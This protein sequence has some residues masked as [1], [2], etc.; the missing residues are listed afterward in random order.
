MSR[1]F[2][3]GLTFCENCLKGSKVIR[4]S[5]D[6]KFVNLGVAEPIELERYFC[7]ELLVCFNIKGGTIGLLVSTDLFSAESSYINSRKLYGFKTLLFL[8]V[9]G[10]GFNFCSCNWDWS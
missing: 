5:R 9:N 2:I 10:I 4:Q 3:L 1:V 8:T 6:W 7:I